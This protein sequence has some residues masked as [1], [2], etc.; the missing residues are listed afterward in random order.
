MRTLN[1]I[2]LVLVAF[3]GGCGSD[4]SDITVSDLIDP[5]NNG[6][7][8]EET[9]DEFTGERTYFTGQEQDNVSI[10][11]SCNDNLE[12]IVTF[13]VFNEEIRGESMQYRVDDSEIRSLLFHGTATAGFDSVGSIGGT[14]AIEFV[15]SL[16]GRERLTVR[17]PVEQYEWYEH[18]D[19]TFTLEGMGVPVSLV[20]TQCSTTR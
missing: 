11:I 7:E 20:A 3:L 19:E 10:V 4:V 9:T 1:N 14:R 12:F 15:T 18:V 16:A 6:W 8:Y 13:G 5:G 2:V 17:I